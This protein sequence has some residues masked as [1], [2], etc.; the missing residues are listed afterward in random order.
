MLNLVNV[1][2]CF[3]EFYSFLT[4][5]ENHHFCENRRKSQLFSDRSAVGVKKFRTPF[6]PALDTVL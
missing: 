6:T 2:K 1:N 3:C 5:V 4:G